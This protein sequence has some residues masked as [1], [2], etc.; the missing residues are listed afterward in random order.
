M[1]N[2]HWSNRPP[3]KTLDEAIGQATAIA[4]ESGQDIGVFFMDER[5]QCLVVKRS[6]WYDTANR[7]KGLRAVV[8]WEGEVLQ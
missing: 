5:Y 2:T 4:R 1:Q 7:P 6:Q 3:S 8:T